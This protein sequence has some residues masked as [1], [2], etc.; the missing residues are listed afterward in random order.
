MKN[1]LIFFLFVIGA[2]QLQAQ[3][4][5]DKAIRNLEQNYPQEKVYLLL[6]KNSY[7]AGDNIFFKSYV[8]E[9]YNRSAIS[10]TLFVELY[11]QSKKLIDKKTISLKNGE[12]NGSFTLKANLNE[13]I[14]FIRAYTT[15][16]ANFPE[17]WNFIKPVPI[18]N[19]DSQQKLV[20]DENPKWTAGVFPEGGTFVAEIPTKVAVRIYSKRFFSEN[21]SG[22]VIDEEKPTEKIVSFKSFD[23]NVSEFFITPKKGKIYKAVIEDGKG[24]KQTVDLPNVLETGINL[25][26][27]SD[28]KG[29]HFTIKGSNLSEGL[30]GYSVVGTMNNH[31]AY[32]ANITTASSEVSSNIPIKSSDNINGVLQLTVFDD[33][34]NVIAQRL[35]FVNPKNLHIEEP[36]FVDFSLNDKPRSFNS[37]DIQPDSDHQN[38]MV[39]V[40]DISDKPADTSEE[41]ILSA[42]W[43]TGDFL[44]PI[45]SPAQYFSENQNPEALDDLLITEK[46][47]RF[48]WNSILAETV[49]NFKY[50]PSTNLSFKGKVTNNGQL[51][52][53]KPINLFFQTENSDKA[54]SQV[55]TDS[56]GFIYL[57]N[58]SFDAPLKIT[59]LLNGSSDKNKNAEPD[60]LEISF[61][62]LVHNIPYKGIFPETDYHLVNS[63]QKIQ[64]DQEV[65][66]AI[67]NI[68]NQKLLH[69]NETQ[70]EEVKI[71]AKKTDPKEQLDK[72]LSSPRFSSFDATI[73]DLVND[74][75]D[76]QT[77]TNI[78]EWLQGRV[79]GLTFQIDDSGNYVPSMRGSNASIY[80]DE[81]PVDAS[82]ISTIPPNIIAMVKVIK[83]GGLVSNAI[84]IYTKKGNM[85]SE[86]EKDKDK[87]QSNSS[88]LLGYDKAIE[89]EHPDFS[90]DEYKKISKDL[91]ELLYW[92]PDLSEDSGLAPRAKFFNN[93][94]AKNRQIIIISFDKDDKLLYYEEVK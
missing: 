29:I 21:W 54:F 33:K 46:W 13:D 79:A 11:N 35:C 17:E 86:K 40:R 41:N 70:I 78:F 8:F 23:R 63:P 22:Y 82:T 28:E 30:K 87:A 10:T 32:K 94:S 89:F 47:K 62:P 12:G 57:N 81:M 71:I 67:Q 58:I 69:E 61:Q 83:T 36:T 84:A 37:F 31:L 42:L 16:M 44:S 92:N 9:G 76:A 66:N 20:Q 18:Y 2:A 27:T 52:I 59:Y 38:Y 60:N 6:D 14:Y 7:V 26:T 39:L 45:Y 50:K 51:V 5:M 1:L 90:K 56:N 53:N 88:I 80:L 24:G 25:Q 49:P 77:S 15:W 55:Q 34:E 19:P 85:K 93:D 65:A 48:D 73:F 68:K 43:L 3:S 4:R 64:Q 75:E 91:R 74:N 72:E